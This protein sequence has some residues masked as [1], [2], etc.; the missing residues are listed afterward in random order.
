MS[1]ESTFVSTESINIPEANELSNN[2][3]QNTPALG[4]FLIPSTSVPGRSDDITGF[5]LT[6]S[7]EYGKLTWTAPA[8][9]TDYVD[10]TAF[11][12]K[13][14]TFYQD[15][16][17]IGTRAENYYIDVM[18]GRIAQLNLIKIRWDFPFTSGEQASIRFYRYRKINGVFSLNQ[19][20]DTI[21]LNEKLD[22]SVW[23]D[24]TSYIRDFNLDPLTDSVV[25]SDVHTGEVPNVRALNVTFGM[26]DST[27]TI[28]TVEDEPP[29]VLGSPPT[30]P[31]V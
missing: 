18:D 19:I 22:W 23:H 30:W 24:F 25:V 1:N 21:V 20:S 29:I 9:T 5:Q 7:N 2:A 14:N 12:A 26:I 3:S 17:P 6:S 11:G 8:P 31:P 10:Q 28:F 13:L 27:D 16:P 15:N 4:V